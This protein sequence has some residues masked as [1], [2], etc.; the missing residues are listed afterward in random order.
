[1][2]KKWIALALFILL[3]AQPAALGVFAQEPEDSQEQEDLQ[4][5]LPFELETE[6]AILMDAG[7]GK[8]ILEKNM[9]Q[10]YYPA[11][12]TKIMT[13]LLAMEG[14]KEGRISLDDEVVVSDNAANMGGSQIFLSPG[15]VVSLE[16]MLIGVGVG[17]GNDAAVAVAEHC[18]GSLETF[19]Q[20]MNEK[21]QCLGMDNTHF[22][23]PHGLHDED[24]YTTAHDVA[25]MSR[26]L[27]KHP[28][29]HTWLT[30][31]MDENFLEGQIRSGKVY[32]SNS[33]KLVRTYHGVDGFKT[34]YTDEAKHCISATAK[35]EDTRFVAVIL[36]AP[37]SDIRFTEAKKLLDYGFAN[38]ISLPVAKAGEE[39]AKVRVEKGKQVM[40]SALVAEDFSILSEKGSPGELRKETEMHQDLLAPVEKGEP[41]GLLKVYQG[42]ELVGTTELTAAESVPRANVLD[43][44]GRI[45]THWLRFGK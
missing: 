27:L 12:V 18:Y 13:M 15:D 7:S 40:L 42:D 4:D 30:I 10:R 31:W 6:G 9:H 38:F 2:L 29:I 16:N 44:L 20:K 25:L 8:I 14:I 21:A 43:L 35:K 17:S 24:H 3:M 5:G 22:T 41:L 19:V 23:N 45:L 26:E 1:M 34:G 28:Q 33:N 11:S 37:S 32:L 36:A 39:I